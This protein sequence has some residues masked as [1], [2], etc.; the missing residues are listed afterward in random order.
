MILRSE[1]FSASTQFVVDHFSDARGETEKRTT[2]SQALAKSG[3]SPDNACP[4]SFEFLEPG[5]R[6]IGASAR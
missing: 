2:C 1:R 6:D 3:R 5:Q 4:Y